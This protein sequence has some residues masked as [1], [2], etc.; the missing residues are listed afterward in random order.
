LGSI[1]SVSTGIKQQPAMEDKVMI[2]MEGKAW[3]CAIRP[4]QPLRNWLGLL[5]MKTVNQLVFSLLSLIFLSLPYFSFSYQLNSSNNCHLNGFVTML[6]TFSAVL[7]GGK[8]VS[9]NVEYIASSAG[10]QG[11]LVCR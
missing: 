9:P 4:W 6:A 5:N 1:L 8:R 10:F 3:R 2:A 11:T 7:F